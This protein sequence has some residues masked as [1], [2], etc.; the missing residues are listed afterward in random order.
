MKG[1]QLAKNL[2]IYTCNSYLL[3]GDWNRLDDVN[4]LIGPDVD[5][6]V[7]EQLESLHR[8]QEGEGGVIRVINQCFRIHVQYILH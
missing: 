5:G 6:S 4:I 3:L 7:I 8:L 2:D 1:M